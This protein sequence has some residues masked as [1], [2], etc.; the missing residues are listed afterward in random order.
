MSFM[1]ASTCGIGAVLMQRC[2][3]STVVVIGYARSQLTKA[4]KNYSVTELEGL[5]VI[6]ATSKFKLYLRAG[7][8][9]IHTDHRALL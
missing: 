5:A 4:E 3:D 8:F 7:H 1:D 2:A 6:F 9:T